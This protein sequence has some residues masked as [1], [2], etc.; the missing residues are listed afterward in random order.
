MLSAAEII[1]FLHLAPL[2]HEG[3]WYR[4]TYRPSLQLVS[5]ITRR[6][7]WEAACLRA[8][9]NPESVLSPPVGTVREN[10]PGD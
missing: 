1:H 4:E 3:G 6:K 2:P 7:P 10:K 9:A 5:R 8:K